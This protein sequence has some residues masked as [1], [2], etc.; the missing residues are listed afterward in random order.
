LFGNG[1]VEC[2]VVDPLTP[3]TGDV[4]PGDLERGSDT[5]VEIEYPLEP[6]LDEWSY[7]S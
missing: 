3:Y 5:V 7:M 1:T 6:D 2:P 4:V